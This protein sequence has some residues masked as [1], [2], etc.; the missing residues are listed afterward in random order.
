MENGDEMSSEQTADYYQKLNKTYYGRT[1]APS[2]CEKF[3][4]TLK[5]KGYVNSQDRITKEDAIKQNLSE[6]ESLTLML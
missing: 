5:K 6:W 3:W 1:V 4:N 2:E